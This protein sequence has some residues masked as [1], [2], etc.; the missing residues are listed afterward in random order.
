M[1]IVDEIL[2]RN[3]KNDDSKNIIG[4]EIKLQRLK[5]A[6]TL[7]AV[8]ANICSVSYLCKIERNAI[9]ANPYFLS[10]ICHRVNIDSNKLESLFNLED[11]ISNI[12]KYIYFDNAKEIVN[13]YD[14]VSTFDNYRANILKFGYHVYFNNLL[15]ASTID[16]LLLNL[17]SNMNDRDIATYACL[18]AIF[19]IKCY[20]YKEASQIF[21]TLLDYKIIS[22]EEKAL[23]YEYMSKM[24]LNI[25][26]VSFLY[27][28][29]KSKE[30]NN[31]LLA[32]NKTKEAIFNKGIYYYINNLEKEFNDILKMPLDEKYINTL[33]LLETIKNDK[34]HEIM[35]GNYYNDFFSL[36]AMYYYNNTM[37]I[38]ELNNNILN[39]KLSDIEIL[40]LKY[41][42][43]DK[44]DEKYLVDLVKD[45]YP[46]ALALNNTY[47]INIITDSVM[48][49]L[50][51]VS[52]YKRALEIIN[53]SNNIV[54]ELLKI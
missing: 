40:V 20:K 36:L 52:Q 9:N 17:V 8:C 13:I 35:S 34:E 30:Y 50:K 46:T 29:E 32:F 2:Q 48:E 27:Y 14:K 22:V 42:G 18:K 7:E 41:I 53:K 28:I 37:F 6:K 24:Y 10:E 38:N 44:N 33:R 19:C 47:V 26:S 45:Y 11:Y 51:N 25:N 39:Y 43:L 54:Q 49:S 4:S 31:N 1:K 23:I 12:D 15:N 5:L 3:D 16:N 21:K